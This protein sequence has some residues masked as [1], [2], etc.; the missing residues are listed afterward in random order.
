MRHCFFLLRPAIVETG[1]ARVSTAVAVGMGNEPLLSV[2]VCICRDVGLPRLT[3]LHR[4]LAPSHTIA[5][6]ACPVPTTT[7]GMVHEALLFSVETCVCVRRGKPAS[8]RLTQKIL[9]ADAE[10]IKWF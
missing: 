8:L 4:G 1:Q 7:A 2:G 5:V 9:A 6:W 10:G 3:P